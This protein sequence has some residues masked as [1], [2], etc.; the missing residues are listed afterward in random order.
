MFTHFPISHWMAF[1]IMLSI[2]GGIRGQTLTNQ[3]TLTIQGSLEVVYQGDLLNE[4][5]GEIVLD[6]SLYVQGDITNNSSTD[7]TTGIGTVVLNGSSEQTIG[8]SHSSRFYHLTQNNTGTGTRL[9]QIVEVE[10]ELNMQDGIIDL[11]AQTL[12]LGTTGEIIGETNDHR[13]I[14]STGK[15]SA[16]RDLNNPS[17]DIAGMGVA[18]SSN[19]NL[20][21]TIIERSHGVVSVG[22]GASIQRKFDIS[23]ANNSNL[24]ATL[25]ISYFSGELNG[26]NSNTLKQWLKSPGA[27]NWTPGILQSSNSGYFTGGPYSTLDGLWTLS[28][29]GTSAIEDLR[30]S[31]S[32]NYFPNPLRHGQS[33]HI[34][35]LEKG[36]YQFS[37]SDMTGR[38]VWTSQS[39]IF[40]PG[41]TEKLTLPLLADGIY[42]LHILSDTYRPILGLLHIQSF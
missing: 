40:S 22:N 19:T 21:T 31:L 38:E 1:G 32:L 20:G 24:D 28:S 5:S 8:G 37:L 11:N 15:I 4:G 17:G 10:G 9:G 7:L 35:G 25:S 33:L 34:E 30:P 41:T 29:D 23:P 27:A 6:G 14:G 39:S 18:I 2:M 13:I 3:S 36:D 12:D 42:S 26:Q 16:T